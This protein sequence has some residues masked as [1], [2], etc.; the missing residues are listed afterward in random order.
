ME[1][2]RVIGTIIISLI[3]V[4]ISGFISYLLLD[5][6]SPD[7]DYFVLWVFKIAE[8]VLIA[9]LIYTS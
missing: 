7:N 5:Y 9:Y 1:F 8:V 3:Y 2:A 6:S 4:S